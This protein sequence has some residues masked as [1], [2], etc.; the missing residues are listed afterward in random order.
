MK[1]PWILPED[2]KEYTSVKSVK[3]RED[4]KLKIDIARA[5]SEVIK[6]CGH[7]FKDEKYTTVPA[8]LKIALII[9]AEAIAYNSIKVFN[10]MKSETFDDYSYTTDSN[11]VDFNSLGIDSLLDE[12][13]TPEQSSGFSLKIR[14]L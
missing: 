13:I 14:K 2:V 6:Y 3:N 12:F 4:E 7:K 1:R 8:N 5:E 9:I 10:N 11:V